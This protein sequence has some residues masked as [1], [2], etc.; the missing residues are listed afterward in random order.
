M[1][2]CPSAQEP[3][4]PRGLG[5]EPQGLNIDETS[6]VGPL[7][8]VYCM[9]TKYGLDRIGQRTQGDRHAPERATERTYD[10][11]IYGLI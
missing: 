4:S 9:Y 3:K 11:R 5:Q 6:E 2:R 1:P 7:D 10:K 8:N